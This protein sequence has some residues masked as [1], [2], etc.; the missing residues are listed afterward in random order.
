MKRL[1]FPIIVLLFFVAIYIINQFSLTNP[2]KTLLGFSEAGQYVQLVNKINNEQA[3]QSWIKT[4]DQII[5]RQPA[6]IKIAQTYYFKALVLAKWRSLIIDRV[7]KSAKTE[8]I[9]KGKMRMV[10][11]TSQFEAIPSP[12][13]S[14]EAAIKVDR[15]F[16]EAYRDYGL[17]LLNDQVKPKEA[18]KYLAIAY[19]LNPEIKIKKALKQC[20]HLSNHS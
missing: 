14:F 12:R 11:D 18:Q 17:W 7:V 3:C 9:G 4:A 15:D 8:K 10:I 6:K 16:S 13:E 5:D 1:L 19:Q 2:Q 20:E